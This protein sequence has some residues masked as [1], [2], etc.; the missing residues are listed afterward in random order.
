MLISQSLN[1]S[2]NS[3]KNNQTALAVVSHNIANL[4]TKGYIKQRVNMSE[5]RLDTFG[6][7]VISKIH[8]LNGA[9]IDSLSSYVDN[10]KLRNLVNS[11]SDAA[12]YNNL[13]DALGGLEDVADALGDSGLNALLNDFYKVSANLEQFPS[14][15]SIR[16]QFV[17]ALE[18][19]CDKFNYINDKYTEIQGDNYNNTVNN[20]SAVNKLLSDLAT[21]NLSHVK[22]GGSPATQN[23]INTILSELSEYVGFT[24]DQNDN[25]SYNVYIGGVGAVLG[26]EQVYELQTSFDEETD[27]PLTITMQSLKDGEKTK[28]ISSTI[29]SGALKANVDFL[30][31]TNA[32]VG[33]TTVAEMKNA[34]I[35]AQN[36]FKDALNEIQQ[37]ANADENEYAA[38]I[39]SENGEL[40]LAA[41]DSEPPIPALP[42]ELL[43]YDPGTNKLKVNPEVINDPYL[44]A[45]ARIDLDNYAEGED[46]TKSI[47]NSDNA[48]FMTELQNKKICSYG[49]GENNCTLSQF[50]INSA[51]KNG[52]DMASAENKADLYNGIAQ[53]A[54][55]DYA[56]MT[57]VNLDEELADMIK[58]QRAFEA[59]AKVFA[60][61]DN[62]LQTIMSL[63]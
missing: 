52:M 45:A 59:S 53:S 17:M 36:A 44:V 5:L 63:V 51:A 26:S 24:Y 34:V 23:Q 38:Y 47:G 27:P 7:T 15:I 57:G 37:Y 14:D 18:N 3:M 25:G 58:Y 42:Q 16:Q 6:N 50:L 60:T 39:K 30:N 21:V 1:I 56:N 40:I 33:F 55:D 43:I 62:I 54:Q 10:S 2:L 31:G 61:A 13:T 49:G 29:T 4:N 9:K 19:V 11:G 32:T 46:W 41:D 48:G 12:Y 22:N 35:E 28:D 20:V 8:S